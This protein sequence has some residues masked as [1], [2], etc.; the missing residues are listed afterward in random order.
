MADAT[1]RTIT[2][3]GFAPADLHNS[4]TYISDEALAILAEKMVLW[5]CA[6]Q[7]I[8]ALSDAD[9]QTLDTGPEIKPS[10]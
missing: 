4:G 1:N 7:V 3:N 2:G 8:P 5:R 9:I 6:T 10:W